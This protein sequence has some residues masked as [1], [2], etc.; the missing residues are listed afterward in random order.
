MNKK[1]SK[2]FRLVLLDWKR[3]L[4]DKFVLIFEMIFC[5]L[6]ITIALVGNVGVS[7]IEREYKK[8]MGCNLVTYFGDYGNP[9]DET[10]E[11]E[12][13]QSY[14][15]GSARQLLYGDIGNWTESA[16]YNTAM[17]NNYQPNLSVG[18]W[19]TDNTGQHTQV[20]LCHDYR[21]KYR[22]GD[23]V[24]CT[25]VNIAKPTEYSYYSQSLQVVGFLDVGS[26]ALGGH[27]DIKKLNAIIYE[28]DNEENFDINEMLLFGAVSKEQ[29]L[30]KYPIDESK[31]KFDSIKSYYD[32]YMMSEGQI[33]SFFRMFALLGV[34]VLITSLLSAV[35]VK[36]K[37]SLVKNVAIIKLG[38]T[39]SELLAS[40][41]VSIVSVILISLLISIF[42]AIPLNAWMVKAMDNIAIS[43]LDVTL[44]AGLVLLIYSIFEFI[45]VFMLY[46]KIKK[47]KK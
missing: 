34:M 6:M 11:K 27:G 40:R 45:D 13:H 20:V 41:A 1:F 23:I 24:N 7:R 46:K 19:F 2:I 15:L 8:I 35:V 33:I 17:V 12:L 21:R 32:I 16:G 9:E 3:N 42:A 43:A 18:D 4:S 39:Q 37:T 5:I 36:R 31:L 10:I 47:E 44:G 30:S 14:Q 38:T 25:E 29:L 22:V 26:F 28:R